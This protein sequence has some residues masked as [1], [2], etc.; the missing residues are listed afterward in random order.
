MLS[1]TFFVLLVIYCDLTRG[2]SNVEP[3]LELS[4]HS[5]VTNSGVFP[6]VAAILQKSTYLCAGALIAE[7]WVLTSADS[8]FL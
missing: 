4:D 1:K 2:Q 7:T 5:L 3:F 8:L 6:Y